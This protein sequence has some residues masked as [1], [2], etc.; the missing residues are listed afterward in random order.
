MT[1]KLT[2]AQI[3][4][5][6][7]KVAQKMPVLFAEIEKGNFKSEFVIDFKRIGDRE[8]RLKLVAEVVNSDNGEVVR[9]E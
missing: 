4:W 6:D 8:V 3:K 5:L 2:D 1:S 9:D 7:E